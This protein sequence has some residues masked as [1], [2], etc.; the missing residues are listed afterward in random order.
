LARRLAAPFFRFLLA[1]QRVPGAD[2]ERDR[3]DGNDGAVRGAEM[4]FQSSALVRAGLQPCQDILPDAC[5]APADK[6]VISRLPGSISGGHIDPPGSGCEHPEDTV[7][8]RAVRA[9]GSSSLAGM[10]WRQKG[11][12]L[13]P[14]FVIRFKA[15][16]GD[17]T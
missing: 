15:C 1:T 5:L 6:A 4:P 14:L 7:D 17:F 8:D 3:M 12:D 16:H 10:L 11:L 2:S 9:I 13:L